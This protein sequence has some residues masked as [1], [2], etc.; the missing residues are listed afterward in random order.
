[1]ALGILC[2]A[3]VCLAVWLCFG[4]RST[5][6]KILAILFPISAFVAAGFEHSIANMYFI[7]I[8]LLI[9]TDAAFLAVIG[10]NMSDYATL[11]W[12]NFVFVNLVP[13]TLG[14]IIGGVVLVGL[15]YWSVY[16]RGGDRALPTSPASVDRQLPKLQTI[17]RD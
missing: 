17:K 15:I 12:A 9:K 4:A 11:T 5:T 1:V 8:G 14:N 10:K 3:L 16:L 2:N 7:P 6:D 13:V